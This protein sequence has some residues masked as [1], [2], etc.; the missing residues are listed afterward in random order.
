MRKA[1]RDLSRELAAGSHRDHA[2]S[3]RWGEAEASRR[4]HRRNSSCPSILE[5]RRVSRGKHRLIRLCALA[6]LYPL[7]ALTVHAQDLY[8]CQRPLGMPSV[9][10]G[11]TATL[12]EMQAAREEVEVFLSEGD[13]FLS[14]L[15]EFPGDSV[16]ATVN[17][18]IV[19]EMDLVVVRF[20]EAL[21]T[22]SEGRQC[23]RETPDADR[24][25][26][27]FEAAD[28]FET[29]ETLSDDPL[30]AGQLREQY[31]DSDSEDPTLGLDVTSSD[32]GPDAPRP[33]PSSSLRNLGPGLQSSE[34]MLPD[35]TPCGSVTQMRNDTSGTGRSL[36][37][38]YAW[39]VYNAC[40]DPIEIRWT[41]R[42][43]GILNSERTVLARGSQIVS[44]STRAGTISGRY[45]TGGFEYVFEWPPEASD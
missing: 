26:A 22:Y 39:E 35:G 34:P 11:Y 19:R 43:D 9:P 23:A 1:R 6:V 21:C 15:A 16:A 44:C 25:R 24:D 13:E 14:C 20:N 3:R 28:S 32:L 33:A 8:G 41:F 12:A 40:F 5:A 36:R 7:T 37:G 27:P 30:G 4:K 38:H 45:C 42:G 18:Q 31:F 29:P 2:R 17:Q 10:D